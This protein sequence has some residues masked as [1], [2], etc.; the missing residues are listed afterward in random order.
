VLLC[1]LSAEFGDLDP[2][3]NGTDYLTECHLLPKALT[4]YVYFLLAGMML[5]AD[6]YENDVIFHYRKS[7]L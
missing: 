2:Q 1:V 4:F 5:H 3:L 6:C 7:M